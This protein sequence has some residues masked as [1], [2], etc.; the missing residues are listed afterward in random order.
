[1]A[2]TGPG[3]TKMEDSPWAAAVTC[4]AAGN[5]AQ[6]TSTRGGPRLQLVQRTEPREAGRPIL[7]W[8]ELLCA[9]AGVCAACGGLTAAKR[10]LLSPEGVR[11]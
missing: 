3:P 10:P 5:A 2:R 9:E 11:G 1:M 6:P 7:G 4:P 8:P